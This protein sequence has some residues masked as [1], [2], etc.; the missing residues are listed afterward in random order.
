MAEL[1][2]FVSSLSLPISILPSRCFSRRR[3]GISHSFR[4]LTSLQTMC[5]R[6]SLSLSV[7]L[8]NLSPL[9]SLF[10]T[11]AKGGRAH[12]SKGMGMAE[13]CMYI[14]RSLT[15][16]AA[17]AISQMRRVP[18]SLKVER[19]QT[20]QEGRSTC[21]HLT[22]SETRRDLWLLGLLSLSR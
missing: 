22:S 14:A 9:S 17:S 4:N 11:R 6:R 16:S 13:I 1:Q 8:R 2:I 15:C 21:S 7:R 18:I 12:C 5:P 3:L 19:K 20:R 10:P